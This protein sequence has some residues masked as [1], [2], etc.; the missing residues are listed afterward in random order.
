M[1]SASALA[2]PRPQAVDRTTYA[3]LVARAA[4]RIER[5]HQVASDDRARL[6]GAPGIG[7][8]VH[9]EV[10]PGEVPPG[11]AL[12]GEVPPGAALPE[13]VQRAGS[14][15]RATERCA[16]DAHRDLAAALAQLGRT[17]LGPDPAPS[18]PTDAES[19]SRSGRGPSNGGRS[20][21]S[22]R[23]PGPSRTLLAGLELYGR[24]RDWADPRP[25]V[26]AAG[27][28]AT[29]ALLIRT[30]ADLWATHHTAYGAPRSPEASKMRH[31]ATLGAATRQWHDLVQ[32][33]AAAGAALGAESPELAHV[34][35]EA[36]SFPAV[37]G[38]RPVGADTSRHDRPLEVTVARPGV[39]RTHG[40][41]TELADRID[42]LRHLAWAA[43]GTTS[44]SRAA[45]TPAI[46]LANLAAIGVALNNATAQAHRHA[47]T[48]TPP[49]AGAAHLAA[50]GHAHVA[51]Q[52][53]RAAAE[54]VRCLR[55]PHP[56]THPVQ[57]ERLDIDALLRQLASASRGPAAI[58]IAWALTRIA[59]AYAEIAE[60]NAEGLVL[61]HEHGDLLL[62]GRAIPR[63][64]L[65]RRPDLL[66][67]RLNDRVINA[68]TLVVDRL[69]D[70][71]RDIAAA[72]CG[73]PEDHLVPD[74]SPPAA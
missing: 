1:S 19:R 60:H 11:A 71:Y 49:A 32:R 41:L 47:A 69:R 63:D 70:L 44:P 28:L 35:N 21:G 65:P 15:P 5:A 45:G 17:L 24:S 25:D 42:R 37:A 16:V 18:T 52:Q 58:E 10:Q 61:A 55:T 14:A 50:A 13:E 9:A 54:L 40:P 46:V 4:R 34:G 56:P 2:G 68:P 38:P 26:S 29:A 33:A 48:T 66:A 3:V 27:D 7:S 36:L 31:P 57:V 53:W 64:A 12:P 59:D 30:A 72:D 23:R 39:R 67:A 8:S 62:L 6:T 22:V 74:V 20:A 43:A 73:R 51:E